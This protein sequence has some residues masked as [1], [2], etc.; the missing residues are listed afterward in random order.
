MKF[1]V[2]R[3]SNILNLDYFTS[4]QITFALKNLRRHLCHGGL[5][6]INRTVE[7]INLFTVFRLESGTFSVVLEHNSGSEIRDPVRDL[8]A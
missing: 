3:A 7:S 4:D 1:D 5:L 8:P 2:I 6:V